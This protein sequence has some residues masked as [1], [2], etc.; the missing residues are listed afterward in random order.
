MS[1]RS[2]VLTSRVIMRSLSR[3]QRIDIISNIL[4]IP[5]SP[6]IELNLPLTV[7]L[8]IDSSAPEQGLDLLKNLIVDSTLKH[9]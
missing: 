1:S 9:D 5:W 2:S 3:L 4:H 8:I 6:R 7:V